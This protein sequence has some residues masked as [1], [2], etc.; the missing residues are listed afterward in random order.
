[1]TAPPGN[2]VSKRRTD[3]A[4]PPHVLIL[5]CGRSGTSI[6]GEL[7][8]HLPGYRYRSEPPFADV[9]E[10]DQRMPQAYKVPRESA[11]YPPTPGL[12]F[13]LDALL[14]AVASPLTLF[15][16]VRHPLDAIASL[17]VGIAEDWGHHPR[18]PDWQRWLGR[19]LVERCAHHWAWIN[20]VGHSAVA[21]RVE[22]ASFEL[23]RFEV[24]RFEE[25]IADPA[26]FA[27][28][29]CAVVG[30]DTEACSPAIGAWADRVQDT[31]NERFVEARTSRP[32]SRPDHSRRV[33]RWRENLSE[34]DVR[35]VTPI[36]AEAAC[37]FGYALDR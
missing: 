24:M 9:I 6:F 32:Y 26:A 2:R 34:D 30:L 5:G 17:R 7:F 12:S 25:M 23:M 13:P 27:R 29:V 10:A 35:A 20:S 14:G 11:G 4:S 36:V 16:Q 28:R 15:W 19:P 22:A 31:N 18:P 1:M 33:G 3:D 8:E 21:S 37:T